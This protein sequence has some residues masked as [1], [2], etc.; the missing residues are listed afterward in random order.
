MTD[1]YDHDWRMANPGDYVAYWRARREQ[2]RSERLARKAKHRRIFT[3][4]LVIGLTVVTLGY[5]GAHLALML[6]GGG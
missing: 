1:P 4:T 5:L 2:E 6:F 3:A